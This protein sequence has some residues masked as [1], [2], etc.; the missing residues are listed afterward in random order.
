MHLDEY[1]WTSL[2]KTRLGRLGC[3]LSSILLE[4]DLCKRNVMNRCYGLGRVARCLSFACLKG[5]LP[6]STVPMIAVQLSLTW[7][8]RHN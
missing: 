1:L 7:S 4:I 3:F 2:M 5:Q 8:M 6:E